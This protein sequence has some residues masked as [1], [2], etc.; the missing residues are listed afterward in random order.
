MTLAYHGRCDGCR[1]LDDAARCAGCDVVLCGGCLAGTG[2]CPSC[3]RPFRTEPPVGAPGA[4][5]ERGRRH[6]HLGAV[7]LFLVLAP[8]AL[9]ASPF[10]VLAWAL[11]LASLLF[12]VQRGGRV[13]RWLLMG[14]CALGVGFAALALT[15][16]E[17]IHV[18]LS[19]VVGAAH[20]WLLLG[21]ARSPAIAALLRS[22]A[23]RY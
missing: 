19:V 5:I 17:G 9:V 6:L 10:A 13:A 22:G 20:L 23:R 2:R 18:P 8:L 21:L 12:A 4:R 3:Q 11:T 7:P 14:A 15:G 16:A 1:G